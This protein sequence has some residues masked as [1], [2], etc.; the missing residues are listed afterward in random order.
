MTIDGNESFE[1]S[2]RGID[3]L[4]RECRFYDVIEHRFNNM[5]IPNIYIAG[6]KCIDFILVSFNILKPITRC[7]MSTFGET[8]SSDHR[9][10]LKKTRISILTLC[11]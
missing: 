4:C 1:K 3:K 5:K 9:A 10:L 7:G 11:Y 6:S 8:T 2:K